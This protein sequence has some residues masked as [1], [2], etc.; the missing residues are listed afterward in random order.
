MKFDA[1][2]KDKA[3]PTP[4][5]W[6]EFCSN[7]IKG[8]TDESMLEILSSSAIGNGT[9]TEFTSFCK[10]QKELKIEEF[11]DEPQRIKELSIDLK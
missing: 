6:G 8:I 11:L 5:S 9:A 3:F 7:L 10:M 4:R 2:S 1:N